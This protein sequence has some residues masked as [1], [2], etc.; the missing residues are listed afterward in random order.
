MA[1]SW[2]LRLDVT[3]PKEKLL[4]KAATALHTGSQARVSL[5]Q[6]PVWLRSLMTVLKYCSRAPGAMHAERFSMDW[7]S[8]K[9]DAQAGL[10][11]LPL[12]LSG[13]LSEK[14]TANGDLRSSTNHL[15]VALT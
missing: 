9:K 11:N 5:S 4:F 10:D 6:T 13:V 7:D 12:Y 14:S 8:D 3:V 15:I 2:E 1:K